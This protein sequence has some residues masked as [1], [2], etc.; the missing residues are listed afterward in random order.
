ME[1]A[2]ESI[3]EEGFRRKTSFVDEFS[4]FFMLRR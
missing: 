1:W 2:V 3:I 4:P